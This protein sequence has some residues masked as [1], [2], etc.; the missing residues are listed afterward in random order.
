MDKEASC[1][2]VELYTRHVYSL[3][4]KGQVKIIHQAKVHA[5]PRVTFHVIGVEELF[6][7]LIKLL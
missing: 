1:E 6:L 2:S 5:H 7:S 3:V 4:P